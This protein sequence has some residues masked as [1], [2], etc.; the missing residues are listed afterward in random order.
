MVLS[1]LGK[2]SVAPGQ[3]VAPADP[4]GRMSATVQS[5]T[6]LYLEVRMAGGPV[7]PARLM[8]DGRGL[9]VGAAKVRLRR[10]GVN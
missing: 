1:G 8:G 4:V 7:D 3:S 10:E 2:V 9:D 5:P 6:E